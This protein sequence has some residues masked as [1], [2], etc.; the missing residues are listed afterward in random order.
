MMHRVIRGSPAI[1]RHLNEHY[2]MV[3]QGLWVGDKYFGGRG[4]Y[5]WYRTGVTYRNLSEFEAAWDARTAADK[6]RRARLR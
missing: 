2:H 3:T 5:Y 6:E 1:I 4:T